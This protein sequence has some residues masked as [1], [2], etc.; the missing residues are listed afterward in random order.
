[1]AK[2]TDVLKKVGVKILKKAVHEA[3][4]AGLERIRAA[5]DEEKSRPATVRPATSD[6]S[7]L[8]KKTVEQFGRR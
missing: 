3:A 6:G 1:M 2:P 4:H 7:P 8:R 5:T